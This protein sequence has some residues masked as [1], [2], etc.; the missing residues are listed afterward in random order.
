MC[1]ALAVRSAAA[2]TSFPWPNDSGDVARYTT[3]EECLAAAGRVRIRVELSGPVWSDTLPLTA[4]QAAAPLPAAVIE[5]ARRCGARF[6]AQ[7]EPVTDFAPLQQLF[8]LAGRDADATTILRRRLAVSAPTA[9]R[10]R[11]AVLDSALQGY[12]YVAFGDAQMRPQPVRLVAAE[13][14][15]VEVG[16]LPDTVHAIA[17]RMLPAF[18]LLR[19]AKNAGDTAMVQR[20]ARRYLD[21]VNRASRADRRD[22]FYQG[23]AAISAYTA[24]IMRDETAL[25][26]SLRHGTRGYIAFKRAAWAKAS[27]ERPDALRFPIGAQAAAVEGSVWFGRDDASTP[28]PSRGKLGLVVFLDYDCRGNS[29]GKCWPAYASLRRLAHRFPTLEVTVMARTHGFFSQMAPPTPAEEAQA[30]HEW[31]Q[32][33]HRLPGALAVTATDFWRLDDPD[34]RRVDRPTA[35]ETHYS[36]GHSWELTPGMAFLVD[37]DGT[38]LEVGTLGLKDSMG[39]PDVEM[40]FAQLIEILLGPQ[41]ASR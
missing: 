33:F 3:V 16:R 2:Q 19:A 24:L 37:R 27:G 20:V 22:P 32:A 7:T 10:E 25:L 38:I 39:V 13:S 35:N 29:N 40:Q 15:L 8:L 23:F 28:R 12:L 21:I 5:T 26:D 30:F 14:L 17:A 9:L 31:W 1:C 41:S 36:F 4:A 6:A 11:A 34:R 18:Q